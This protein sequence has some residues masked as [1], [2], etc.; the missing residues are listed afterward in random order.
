MGWA[1]NVPDLI[2]YAVPGFVLLVALEAA[3]D[4]VMRR[5]L[6]EVKDTAASLTMGIG[7]LLVNLLAKALQFSI[8]SALH[9]FALFHVG[10]Q[11]WAWLYGVNVFLSVKGAWALSYVEHFWSLAVEEHF[12][13]VWPFVVWRL[14]DVGNDRIANFWAALAW[15][16]HDGTWSQPPAG[17]ARSFPVWAYFVDDS[18]VTQL[19]ETAAMAPGIVVYT[20]EPT[21]T[22]DLRA[23]C[24][25][26]DLSVV[27]EQRSA[28]CLQDAD[29]L[30][31]GA[32][33]G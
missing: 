14:T 18:Q 9:R 30:V 22:S 3:A 24:P 32:G 25:S 2:Q 12:Y 4:A 20:A 13:F 6:Y 1:S 21:V 27:V 8:F 10:Y 31:R 5:D 7:N 19:C 33:L 17:A 23:T 16:S 15:A 29:A 28:R 11:W 26:A